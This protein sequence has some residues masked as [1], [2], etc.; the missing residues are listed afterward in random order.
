ME[1]RGR[2]GKFS[3]IESP[4]NHKIDAN[5]FKDC[6]RTLHLAVLIFTLSALAGCSA[7]GLESKRVDYKSG[8]GKVLPLDVPPDLTTP[9]AGDRYTIPENGGEAVAVFS[10]YSKGGTAPQPC[11]VSNV[12]PDVKTVHLERNG[13]QRWLVVADRAEN[14]WPLVKEFWL[15]NGF[16]IQTDNPEA[17]LMETDWQEDRAKIPQG[18]LR[19]VI[20]KVFDKV[21]SSDKKD[22]YRTRLERSKEGG[23]TE[24]YL[25]HRGMEE[26]QNADKNGYTW[27]SRGHDPEMEAGMLQLLMVKLGGGP[28]VQA[29]PEVPAESAQGSFVAPKLHEIEGG[30]QSI[31][32]S[33]PFDKSWRKVGLALEQAGMM[34]DDLDRANGVYFVSMRKGIEQKKGLLDRLKFWRKD[35]SSKPVLG[36]GDVAARYQVTVHES[37]AVSE[38]N[39]LNMA[40]GRDQTSQLIIESLYK[41]LIK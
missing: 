13:P 9:E 33:E 38:V 22:M 37:N 12:L 14:V 1:R 29:K 27:R 31:L 36:A 2:G 10:D 15:E 34:A 8:A 18:K 26:V 11:V 16:V 3:P 23:K 41:Q 24:I 28:A 20:G 39:A 19:S 5:N 4:M 35:E 32:L 6:M 25:S 17:G 30:G 21:Y 7:V 40:G